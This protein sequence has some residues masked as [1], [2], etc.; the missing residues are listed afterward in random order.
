MRRQLSLEK[1]DRPLQS[2]L[3]DCQSDGRKHFHV[4]ELFFDH[5]AF[6]V[7]DDLLC[8]LVNWC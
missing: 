3:D 5:E 8:S 6:R 7:L 1:G 4:D 2:C